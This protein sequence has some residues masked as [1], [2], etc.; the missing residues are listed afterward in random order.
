MDKCEQRI[1]MYG[2]HAN[3]RLCNCLYRQMAQARPARIQYLIVGEWLLIDRG[4]KRLLRYPQPYH[5]EA[6]GVFYLSAFSFLWRRI[7]GQFR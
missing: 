5:P 1:V 3:S 2:R 6:S 4:V 7:T